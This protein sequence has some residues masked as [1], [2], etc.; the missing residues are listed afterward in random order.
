MTN[1]SGISDLPDAARGTSLPVLNYSTGAGWHSW[2]RA[3][4]LAGATRIVKANLPDGSRSL[5]EQYGFQ[6]TVSRRTELQ[7]ELNGGPEGYVW[8]VGKLAR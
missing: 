4:S 6:L 3:R 1:H 8:S 7:R 5:V 2:G